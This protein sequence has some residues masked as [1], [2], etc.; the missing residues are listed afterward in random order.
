MT[1]A[2]VVLDTNCVVSALLFAH[3]RLAWLR[4]A[5]RDGPIL[6]LVSQATSAELLRVLTYPKLRLEPDEREDLLEEFLPFA[7]TVVISEPPPVVPLLTDADDRVFLGLA[8][9]GRADVLV[10]GDRTILAAGTAFP[11]PILTPAALRGRLGL[12]EA[13][14]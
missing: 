4:T 9:A 5:W 1:R 13:R 10:S 11:I 14:P 6:P 3:G 8:L 12:D 2:R 7:E